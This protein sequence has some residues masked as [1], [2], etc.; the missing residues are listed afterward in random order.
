MKIGNIEITIEERRE[1][2]PEYYNLR[3]ALVLGD[4]IAMEEFHHFHESNVAEIAFNCENDNLEELYKLPTIKKMVLVENTINNA[5]FVCEKFS[6]A[7]P[8]EE[9][10]LYMEERVSEDFKFSFRDVVYFGYWEDVE[11]PYKKSYDYKLITYELI[12][13]ALEVWEANRSD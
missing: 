7:L 8:V 6:S 3:F 5:D 4:W 11:V 13:I 2:F 10:S 9:K 12:R 1:D